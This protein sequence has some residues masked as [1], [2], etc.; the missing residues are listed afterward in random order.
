[1]RRTKSKNSTKKRAGDQESEVR[2]QKAEGERP[3]A[4]DGY[5]T[6]DCAPVFGILGVVFA[7]I[8][9]KQLF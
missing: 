4:S 8:D 5:F 1:M 3:G 6:F 7:A 2:D 9:R